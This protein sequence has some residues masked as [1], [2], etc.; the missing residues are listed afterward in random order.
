M[1]DVEELDYK[2]LDYL[3]KHTFIGP[4]AM[5]KI[6]RARKQ[7]DDFRK[8]YQEREGELLSADYTAADELEYQIRFNAFQ[9]SLCK[10][11][12]QYGDGTGLQEFA[13]GIIEQNIDNVKSR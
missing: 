11:W 3:R 5:L 8:W 13:E 10:L 7:A 1:Y 9:N 4:L 2:K 6:S 12:S